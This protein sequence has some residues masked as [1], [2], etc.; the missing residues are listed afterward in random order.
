M[1]QLWVEACLRYRSD[2]VLA[3][4]R[5][6]ADTQWHLARRLQEDVGFCLGDGHSGGRVPQQTLLDEL[7]DAFGT[8]FEALRGHAFAASADAA[9]QAWPDCLYHF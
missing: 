4:L 8:T 9:N 3:S 1:E 5:G 6:Q 2:A 7:D